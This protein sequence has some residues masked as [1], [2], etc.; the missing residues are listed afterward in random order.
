MIGHEVRVVLERR[1][2]ANTAAP[3]WRSA[4]ETLARYP[5][6]PVV[7][8]AS[9]LEAAGKLGLALLFDLT[10]R[11]PPPG[12]AVELR[13]LAPNLAA[14]VRVYDPQDFVAPAGTRR[15]MGTFEQVGRATAGE[16]G[17]LK[18]LLE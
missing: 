4:L 5:D 7:V 13:A 17:Y 2:T 11:E 18:E 12:A 3:I 8:D 15:H 1:I 9:Q 16:L 14:L 6:R 10:R